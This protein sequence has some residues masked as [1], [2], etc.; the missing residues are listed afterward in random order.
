MATQATVLRV[1]VPV[2]IPGGF[3]YLWPG[4]GT[5]PAPG[6]RVR[7]PL[8]KG[9][10]IGTVLEHAEMSRIAPD[11]LK[12]VL[13]VV[14]STPVIGSDLLETLTW[15]AD[16][17]HHPIGE[18]VSQAVPVLLRRGRSL[19]T[20]EAIGWRLTD[21]GRTQNV[22]LVGKRAPRQALALEALAG[23]AAIS[24]ETLRSAGIG[25]DTLTRLA[26]KSWIQ[27]AAL[28]GDTE[29]RSRGTTD[30]IAVP[31]LNEDQQAVL[32]VIFASPT[33]FHPFLLQGV[34]GSGK[35]EIYLRLIGRQLQ[36]KRQSLLLVPEIGLTPQLVARLEQRFGER[37]AL[38]HSGL[39][40]RERL[41]AWHDVYSGDVR[42]I[43]GTRS[44]IFA[45]LRNPGL[46]I[47]DEEHD[48][49]YKQQEGFRYSARDL[50]VF[51][52]RQLSIPVLLASATP[53]LESIH[54][55]HQGRYELLSMPQRIGSA[56]TPSVRIIDLNLHAARH[57][58]S[59]PLITAMEQHLANGNQ[60]LLF[61]NRRGFA[62]VLFCAECR[63]VEEC[64]NC[65]SRMTIH[66]ASGELRCH[67][68]GSQIPLTWACGEC[69]AERIA[70]GAGTQRVKDELTALFP[71]TRIARLDR[72]I[73]NRKG[74]L[75][76]VLAD[77]EHGDTQILVGTQMLTKG[78]DFPRVTLV[79]VLNADQGLLG[80]D[81]RSNERLAQTLL[82]VAGRAGRRDKPG[83][84]Y[85]QTHYPTHPLLNCL[86]QHDYTAFAEL[87][88]KERQ[89]T[90]WPPYSHLI[91]WRAQAN[92]RTPVFQ[93]LARVA[94]HAR[95]EAG[96]VTTLG[97]A[98]ATMERRG[99]KFRAQL[100]FQSQERT[101]L[102]ELVGELLDVA[103]AWPESR[104]IRWSIDVD[105][106]EL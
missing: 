77:V 87:A 11:K 73:A 20:G 56:G 33:G 64:A 90:L 27:R 58:L 40:D 16:Y 4:P 106:V 26:D 22:A 23:G 84:V 95:R 41:S 7:V 70:I 67:H 102:H 13:N 53:S 105:P 78:H 21:A 92:S 28:A 47:V 32:G 83:E 96:K 71:Q 76:E 59:T 49:S 42:I 45:P 24:P 93:F 5:P 99:G 74:I 62:P 43:V 55:A 10:R 57:G 65:D 100:L 39:T 36:A 85:V 34:T 17:Y 54:N 52:A 89:E 72:D 6:C 46:I 2:P 35:T 31:E 18:V 9:E 37:L 97:P 48:T 69:G 12:E 88:L 29:G 60:V 44:A 61:L 38:M 75:A 79:G 19:P 103:R 30:V 82:Q 63:S 8:G 68:C 101:P 66:A 51:R 15:C 86:I 14:D 98:P 50:A 80:V 81:F 1:A 91:V 104:R 94:Q 3:D 25:R